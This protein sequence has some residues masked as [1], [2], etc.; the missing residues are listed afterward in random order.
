MGDGTAHSL[1]PVPRAAP[2]GMGVREGILVSLR[3]PNTLALPPLSGLSC[4]GLAISEE[5]EH[6]R[7]NDLGQPSEAG[8]ASPAPE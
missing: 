5:I 8:G 4:Q 7:K 1:P 6:L 2:A 3:W